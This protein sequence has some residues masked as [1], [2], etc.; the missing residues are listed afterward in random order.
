MRHFAQVLI[1]A[2]GL[3]GLLPLAASAQPQPPA[4]AAS[5]PA[6]AA[7]PAPART[8]TEPARGVSCRAISAEMRGSGPYTRE[9]VVQELV[10]ARAEGEMDFHIST[11]PPALQ[12]PMCPLP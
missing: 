7:A 6:P 4:P 5:A 3:A 12:R 8:R 10:R 2:A 11:T 9:A 1:A